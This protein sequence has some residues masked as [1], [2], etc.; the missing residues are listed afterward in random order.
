MPVTYDRWVL[1]TPEDEREQLL[2]RELRQERREVMA[3]M[4]WDQEREDA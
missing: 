2:A 4:R 3:E 1:M